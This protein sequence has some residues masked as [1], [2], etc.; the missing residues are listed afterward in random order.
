[1]GDPQVLVGLDDVRWDVEYEVSA[2]HLMDVVLDD[3]VQYFF[4][5]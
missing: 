3:S 4:V 2:D 5:T 1:L